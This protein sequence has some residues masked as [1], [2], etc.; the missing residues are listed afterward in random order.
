MD[1]WAVGCI[2]YTL[3]VGKPPFET[4]TLKET[5]SRI[6]N[7]QYTIPPNLNIYASK[8]I[9]KLLSPQAVSRPMAKEVLNDPFFS[10]GLMPRHL[11]SSCLTMTPRFD[12]RSTIHPCQQ[13]MMNRPALTELRGQPGSSRPNNRQDPEITYSEGINYRDQVQLLIN[14]LKDIELSYQC[15]KNNA[16]SYISV[17]IETPEIAPFYWISKWVD[18]SDKYGLSYQLCDG[19]SGVLFNDSS[20]IVL[21]A[22]NETVQYIDSVNVENFYTIDVYPQLCTKKMT[23]LKYFRTYMNENLVQTGQ[24]TKVPEA[25]VFSRLPFLYKWFRHQTA[26]VFLLS[27]G[28]VQMNFFECH[29][30]LIFCPVMKAVTLI[31]TDKNF[32]T[33]KLRDLNEVPYPYKVNKLLRTAE[34][35]MCQLLQTVSTPSGGAVMAK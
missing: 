22:D 4:Q 30:K 12:R 35:A 5:Y 27:N 8:L 9:R 24:Q 18:Y 6:K 15:S 14:A 19:S 7:N 32:H 16:P 26:I 25:E 2:L 31:D 3:L 29:S 13:P 34:K 11:P 20:R 10:S 17:D 1:V 21:Y 33:F 28:S 23:L